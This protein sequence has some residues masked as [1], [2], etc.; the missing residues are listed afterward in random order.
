MDNSSKAV[1]AALQRLRE[2]W[3]AHAASKPFTHDRLVTT[4]AGLDAER[5]YRAA[6]RAERKP[7]ADCSRCKRRIKPGQPMVWQWRHGQSVPLCLRC[8]R[9]KHKGDYSGRL[10]ESDQRPCEI[11]ARPMY[12]D[13]YSWQG[14]TLQARQPL[15]CS[16]QCNY[17][18]K[19]RLQLARKKVE[20]ATVACV[21]CGEMF[22]QR[23]RDAQT[24]SA[25]CRQKLFRQRHR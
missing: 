24:C 23:R 10:A 19:V 5:E 25:A 9:T 2:G 22:T 17:R 1:D 14:I 8:H 12:L 21:V 11:C 13:G 15:T 16:Y 7:R 3:T 18:R 20:P 4:F 6:L